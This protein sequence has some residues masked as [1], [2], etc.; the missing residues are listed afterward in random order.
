MCQI[1]NN[2]TKEQI[3]AECHQW[4]FVARNDNAPEIIQFEDLQKS[5]SRPVSGKNMRRC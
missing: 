1:D 2:P 5:G 3:T 4:V